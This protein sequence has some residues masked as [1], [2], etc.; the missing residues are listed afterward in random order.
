MLSRAQVK[1]K[2]KLSDTTNSL[3]GARPCSLTTVIVTQAGM[4]VCS[5]VPIF[6][7]M[8]SGPERIC[9]R[10]VSENNRMH[11][12]WVEYE[13]RRVHEKNGWREDEK[14]I[15]VAKLRFTLIESPF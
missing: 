13:H 7:P 15:F 11:D 12:P 6:R 10:F 14:S 9:F 8:I 1:T 4:P 2:K 3:R 5:S